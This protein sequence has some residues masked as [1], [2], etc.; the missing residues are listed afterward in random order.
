MTNNLPATAKAQTTEIK[1]LIDN[2]ASRLA[3]VAPAWLSVERMTRLALAARSRSPK[4]ASCTP[5]SFLLFCMQCAETGLEPIGAG[6]A[7]PVPF[8]NNAI[9]GYEVQFIPD[10]RG[11]IFLAKKGGFITHAYADVICEN[12]TYAY[13]KGDSP[14]L[15]HFPAINK[16]GKAIAA[17]CVAVLPDG[18]KHIEVVPL[19]DLQSI[20]R[21]SK[22]STGPWKTDWNEMA[23]K[24]AVRRAMKPFKASPQMAAALLADNA[25]TGFQAE[26]EPIA[27][28][29]MKPVEQPEVSEP[30]YSEP[31][32]PPPTTDPAAGTGSEE[33]EIRIVLCTSKPTT[34][35]GNKYSYKGA[36]DEWYYTFDDK[37]NDGIEK[38]GFY[39]IAYEQNQY[40][41]KINSINR[42]A[43][44]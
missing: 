9:N 20:E 15:D 17:Y 8:K 28:I 1:R 29:R 24:T 25:A 22:A 11:L 18:S 30:E 40:G 6:G 4:L 2:S 23:K 19:E 37:V 42:L 35:G 7:W 44:E 13:Q 26:P 12:D 33:I 32:P 38:D 36:D 3:E 27:P 14:K 5:E 31:E 16:R 43:G 41:R 10:W 21:R 34:R 39:L